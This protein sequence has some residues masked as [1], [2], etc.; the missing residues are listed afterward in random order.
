MVTEIEE[1]RLKVANLQ[2]LLK[3]VH[4]VAGEAFDAWDSDNDMRVGKILNALSGGIPGYRSDIDEIVEAVLQIDRLT[5][6]QP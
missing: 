6:T 3:S 5:I 4:S 2:R 1:L